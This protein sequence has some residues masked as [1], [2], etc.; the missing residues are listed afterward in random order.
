MT[1]TMTD[2]L[3]I[4]FFAYMD[5]YQVSDIMKLW[6]DLKKTYSKL[7]MLPFFI[8]ALSLGLSKFP[9]MN[10]NVNPETDEQGYIKEYVIKADHNIAVAIDSPHGLLVPTLKRVQE[11]SIF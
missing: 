2:A 5:D 7:T 10:V 4:P 11:K 3:H 6:Q 8:K 1:K 9:L